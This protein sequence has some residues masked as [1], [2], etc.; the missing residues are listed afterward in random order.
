MGRPSVL[1]EP[2]KVDILKQLAEDVPIREV[3]RRTGVSEATLRRNFSAQVQK[4]KE[5]GTALARVEH[6]LT[7]LPVSAQRAA[8]SMAERMKSIQGGYATAADRS[9][10]TAV[11]LANLA[12]R[13]A[14]QI[15]DEGEVD[16]QHLKD[17]LTVSEIQKAANVALLPASNLIAANK[18]KAGEEE[19]ES[20]PAVLN[21]LP[22]RPSIDDQSIKKVAGLGIVPVKTPE[23]H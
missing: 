10:Q 3:A 2:M 7:Q 14:D 21:I 20:G 19:S 6:D 9:T 1:T 15:P 17:A 11:K 4:V 18:P 8:I 23:K 13:L 5:V 12:G 16:T 22:I